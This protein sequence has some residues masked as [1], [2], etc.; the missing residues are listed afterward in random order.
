MRSGALVL[1]AALVTGTLQVARADGHEAVH[2]RTSTGS[3]ASLRVDQHV[4][5]AL[6]AHGYG[7]VPVGRATFVV[8]PAVTRLAISSAQVSCAIELRIAPLDGRGRERWDAG[9]TAIARGSATVTPGGSHGA[10]E[11]VQA[12]T[13]DSMQR[14]VLPF[15]DSQQRVA[16]F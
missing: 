8:T 11:C 14:R 10:A 2:V 9:R 1:V 16:Q 3:H 5:T 15:L 7:V 13:L 12:A 4:R 6:R